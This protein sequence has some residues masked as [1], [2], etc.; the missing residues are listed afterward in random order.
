MTVP[1]PLGE[2]SAHSVMSGKATGGGGLAG[3]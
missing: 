3:P 1:E 2:G